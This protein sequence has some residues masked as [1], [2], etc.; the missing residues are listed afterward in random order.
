MRSSYFT[1]I[2]LVAVCTSFQ[3]L[4]QASTATDDI[5]NSLRPTAAQL[6]GP[7]RGILPAVPQAEPPIAPRQRV[8]RAS[9][10]P[11]AASVAP[12]GRE[13]PSVKLWIDFV[14]GSATLSPQAERQLG[15]LGQALTNPALEK[16]RFRIE[17]HTDT[18]GTP[19][20]N[21]DLSERRA[22]AVSAYLEQKFSIDPSRL[23][24]VGLGMSELL[25]A[26][27]ENTPEPRNRR[28]RIVNLS[29]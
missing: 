15:A 23:E 26:T 6:S 29:G 11:R 12:A 17:G 14:T 13:L 21:K 1:M 4:G 3:A 7:S 2:S 9:Y 22:Q 28:V 8:S 16:C 25:V 27:P 18:V 24:P 19:E 20:A 10:V 5:V